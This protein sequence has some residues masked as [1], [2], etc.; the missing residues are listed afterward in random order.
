MFALVL[1]KSE[2]VRTLPLALNYF[3]FAVFVR[4]YCYVCRYYDGCFASI[5]VYVLLQEQVTG[6]LVAGSVKG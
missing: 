4:L 6:S 2:R 5:L 1:T 3:L